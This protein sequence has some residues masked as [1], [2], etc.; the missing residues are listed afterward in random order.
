MAMSNQLKCP[1]CG[2]EKLTA[3]THSLALQHAGQ[4]ILVSGLEHYDCATCGA[5]PAFPDQVRRN[6]L[7]ILDARREAQKLL[8]G[9]E[10]RQIREGLGVSQAEAAAI[11][12]GGAHAFSKYERGDVMQSVPMDRL[13][14]V[15]RAFPQVV[16]YLCQAFSLPAPSKAATSVHGGA[17]YVL[18]GDELKVSDNCVFYDVYAPIDPDD[19]SIGANSTFVFG[20][21]GTVQVPHDASAL[22]ELGFRKE[23]SARHMV[24]SGDRVMESEYPKD[25]AQLLRTVACIGSA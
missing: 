16:T 17:V 5:D 3:A 22:E 14:R 15:A 23:G 7:K 12:G 20:C 1:V 10:I 6:D 18:A 11:F 8:T 19:V 13:L 2:G 9:A 4:E 24:W 25:D 21:T